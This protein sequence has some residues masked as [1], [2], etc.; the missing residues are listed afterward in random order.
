MA[1]RVLVTM[2]I[3]C[4]KYMKLGNSFSDKNKPIHALRNIYAS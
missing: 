2:T 3:A 4:D 1:V